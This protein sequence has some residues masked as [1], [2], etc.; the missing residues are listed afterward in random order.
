MKRSALL[1]GVLLPAVALS[2]TILPHTLAQ[3]FAASDRVALV[4]VLSRVTEPQ[5]DG[6][7]LKT[8]TR[9]LVGEDLKG[10]GP[11]EVTLVQLG[12]RS[13]ATEAFVPGDADFSVGETALVFLHCRTPERCFLVAL[14]EG[15]VAIDGGDAVVHDLFTGA[16]SKK[17]LKALKRELLEGARKPEHAR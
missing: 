9:L 6:K 13:G 15:K 4:Q 10:S 1:V 17:P 14:G 8:Y 12:G 16:F 5:A 2:S 3:R 11:R 7:N